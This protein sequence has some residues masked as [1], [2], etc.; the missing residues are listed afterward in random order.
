MTDGNLQFV[1]VRLLWM[2][3]RVCELQP[4]L[5]V[6]EAPDLCEPEATH[7]TLGSL[8]SYL[9]HNQEPEVSVAGI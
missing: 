1:S 9:L 8:D 3:R 7:I 6:R 5:H 4:H 2:C